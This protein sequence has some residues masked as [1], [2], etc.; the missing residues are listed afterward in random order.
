MLTAP[1]PSSQRAY[2]VVC[3]A[4]IGEVGIEAVVDRIMEPLAEPVVVYKRGEAVAE[5]DAADAHLPED[6][7]DEDLDDLE[8]GGVDFGDEVEA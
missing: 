8:D 3:A 1:A 4:C 2:S 5:E 7:D 6:G